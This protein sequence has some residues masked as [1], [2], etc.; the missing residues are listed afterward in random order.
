LLGSWDNVN[1]NTSLHFDDA[2]GF[3]LDDWGNDDTTVGTYNVRGSRLT[4]SSSSKPTAN[5]LVSFASGHLIFS[6]AD[7]SFVGDYVRAS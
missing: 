1:G 6:A 2:D 4:L 3:R 5:Y 7:G